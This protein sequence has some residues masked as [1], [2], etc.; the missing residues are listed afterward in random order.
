M[1]CGKLAGAVFINLCKAFD[2]VDHA[3]LI[4]KIK[5]L[6]VFENQLNWFTDY[7]FH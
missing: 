2:M 4:Q 5:M 1:D 3:V 7:L 6:G